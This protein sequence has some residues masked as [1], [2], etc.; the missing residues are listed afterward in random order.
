MQAKQDLELFTFGKCS[1]IGQG[2]TGRQTVIKPA[3]SI[4]L[5]EQAGAWHCCVAAAACAERQQ[6]SRSRWVGFFVGHLV[7][8]IFGLKRPQLTTT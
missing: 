8:N 1:L 6:K 7:L 2:P 4:E 5:W 3:I